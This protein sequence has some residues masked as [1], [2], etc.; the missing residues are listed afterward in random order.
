MKPRPQKRKEHHNTAPKLHLVP[1]PRIVAPKGCDPIASG[2]YSMRRGRFPKHDPF[3]LV[4]DFLFPRITLDSLYLTV[5][6]QGAATFASDNWSWFGPFMGKVRIA[7]DESPWPRCAVSLV[8]RRF[9]EGPKEP[10]SGLRYKTLAGLYFSVPSKL[11]PAD[12]YWIET[13]EDNMKKAACL[14]SSFSSM[15]PESEI[16]FGPKGSPT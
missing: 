10:I 2:F 12:G 3:S 16:R 11:S 8:I 6:A 7:M 15:F 13:S 5:N 1:I 14:F 4:S 9:E